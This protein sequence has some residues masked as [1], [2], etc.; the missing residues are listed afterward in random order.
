MITRRFGKAVESAACKAIR[1]LIVL[2]VIVAGACAT[3][4]SQGVGAAASVAPIDLQADRMMVTPVSRDWR[5]SGGDDSRWADPAFDD[6]K[7]KVLQPTAEWDAQGFASVNHLAW[8]RFRLRV[9][10]SMP[11]LVLEMPGLTMAYQIF[12]D[13]K[14][15]GQAG[16]L[17]PQTPE[18]AA[19]TQRI[20]TLPLSGSRRLPN[21]DVKEILVAIRLWQD[22]RLTRLTTDVVGTVYAG[23]PKSVQAIFSLSKARNLLVRG[24]DYTQSI[25]S[26]IVGASGL[27]LF[28]LTRRALYAWFTLNMLL[29]TLTLPV[30]W[31]SE[32][33]G[34]G[35][36]TN[37]YAYAALDFLSAL[38]Y[39]L[40]VLAALRLLR[41]RLASFLALLGF[42]S[43]L[44][45]ILF[46][47]GNIS[48]S[49]AD[50]IYFFC[51]TLPD[52]I[53][54]VLLIRAWRA[55][56]T[57]AKLLLFPYALSIVIASVGNLGHWLVDLNVPHASLLL[58]ANMQLLN[59]PFDVALSD[60]GSAVATLGLLAVLV[61]QFAQSSR[62]EQRLKSAL[63]TAHDIQQSLVPVDIPCLGG[64]KTEIVY[65]AAEEVGGDFCQV[66]PRAD[67]SILIVIGDVSGKGLQA[68]MVGTLAVGALRS[69]ADEEIGPAETLKRLNNVLLRTPNRGFITCLCMILTS[70]GQVILA[71]AGHL[72]PYLNGVEMATEPGL[73]LGFVPDMEYEQ[74]SFFLPATARLTLMSDGVVEARSQTGELYGFERTSKISGRPAKDI[75]AE[76]NRFGQEDDITVITLDWRL[77]VN[78]M[79]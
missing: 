17:P 69:M 59:Y 55:N 23:S 60:V 1:A 28:F 52:A 16:S 41:W 75:A 38:T 4:S 29:G 5:F 9:P 10:A 27:L 46:I 36:F 43:E 31:A 44:G 66:L 72:S 20:F 32:H 12:A 30:R 8:F 19:R 45:P 18:V 37:V 57:Y 7:W 61:Y 35:F 68:A 73:P 63:Q 49:W 78:A 21:S 65:L 51:S 70:S 58:T 71:N 26:L 79:A 67:E 50:G 14:L 40:F 22:P 54:I 77:Q 13:G 42:L 56:V 24:N 47:L 64:L 6:S 76:A 48:Q 74:T 2:W 11:S 53:V 15:A 39:T 3:A 33:F 25:V 34:W 62:Q